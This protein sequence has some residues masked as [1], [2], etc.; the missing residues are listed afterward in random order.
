MYPFSQL[1][2]IPINGTK[3]PS[4]LSKFSE[5]Y[6]IFHRVVLVAFGEMHWAFST[7]NFDSIAVVLLGDSRGASSWMGVVG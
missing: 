5:M 6:G 4:T 3:Q 1:S 2:V 7:S